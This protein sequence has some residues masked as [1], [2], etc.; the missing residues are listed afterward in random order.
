MGGAPGDAVP[1]GLVGEVGAAQAANTAGTAR[2]DSAR[3]VRLSSGRA[4]SWASRSPGASGT[5]S[6]GPARSRPLAIGWPHDLTKAQIDDGKNELRI[7]AVRRSEED[8]SASMLTTG[9]G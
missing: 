5:A 2:V 9:T 7:V 6:I 3:I 4:S 8:R 1:S